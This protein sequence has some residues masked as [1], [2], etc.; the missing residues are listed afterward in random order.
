MCS[1]YDKQ[2]NVYNL[3][4][5]KTRCISK[6]HDQINV[7]FKPKTYFC[8]ALFNNVNFL[9]LKLLRKIDEIPF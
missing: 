5:S 9:I 3:K 7:I 8:E 1:Q 2:R 6:K 4:P